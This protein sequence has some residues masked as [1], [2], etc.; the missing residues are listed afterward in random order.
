MKKNYGN[1]ND[2]RQAVKSL[3]KKQEKSN[4]TEIK[5]PSKHFWL[6]SQGFKIK[7]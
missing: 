1:L 3:L 2:G 7:F 4:H 5:V 6:I